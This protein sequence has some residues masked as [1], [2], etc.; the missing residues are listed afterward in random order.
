MVEQ[1]KVTEWLAD[2]PKMMG[3]LWA[4]ALIWA[5]TSS[6]AAASTSATSG[7]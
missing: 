2:N 6:V 4:L 3:V 5:E 1:T 7:P